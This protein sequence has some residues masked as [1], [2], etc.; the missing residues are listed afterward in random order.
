MAS[1]IDA[2]FRR[3]IA[4]ADRDALAME[5]EQVLKEKA[6]QG[7]GIFVFTDYPDGLIGFTLRKLLVD[8]DDRCCPADLEVLAD[9]LVEFY[10]FPK[11][12]VPPRL[13]VREALAMTVHRRGIIER[14]QCELGQ[15][16]DLAPLLERTA[17]TIQYTEDAFLLDDERVGVILDELKST[18]LNEGT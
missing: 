16:V 15:F 12:W 17:A 8:G 5:A 10:S 9:Q 3:F 18:G 6:P 7:G 14:L 2:L 1:D 13:L 11:D 4:R